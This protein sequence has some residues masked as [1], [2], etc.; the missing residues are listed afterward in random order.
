MTNNTST[1]GR[2]CAH[3]FLQEPG[4][5]DLGA[6]G[7]EGNVGQ[8]AHLG[9]RRGEGDHRADEFAGRGGARGRHRLRRQDRRQDERV[10]T[11]PPKVVLAQLDNVH[12]GRFL[13]NERADA[14]MPAHASCPC[15]P[16][17]LAVQPT[18]K[19]KKRVGCGRGR[20]VLVRGAT[21]WTSAVGR[22]AR[23]ATYGPRRQRRPSIGQ[24]SSGG[25]SDRPPTMTRTRGAHRS[26]C[27]VVLSR[28]ARRRR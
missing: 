3:P 21:A 23:R 18:R 13:P 11:R 4:V 8:G 2:S 1:T 15:A 25:G 20:M 14:R 10:R 22:G 26:A 28:R 6:R 16:F 27:V 9:A 24:A 19:C 12:A 5:A 7:R 17:A